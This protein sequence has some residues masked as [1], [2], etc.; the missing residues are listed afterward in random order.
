L[1]M[2]S[3]AVEFIIWDGLL[4]KG[5]VGRTTFRLIGTQAQIARMRMNHGIRYV[6]RVARIA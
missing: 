3:D 1:K 2:Q 4:D 5:T 6:L